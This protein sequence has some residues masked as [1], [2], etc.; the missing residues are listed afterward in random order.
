MDEFDEDQY[1]SL[2]R[3]RTVVDGVLVAV[4]G[5]IGAATVIFVM[6]QLG[7]GSLT[8]PL[9]DVLVVSGRH[10]L[11]AAVGVTAGIGLFYTRNRRLVTGT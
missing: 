6:I 9:G 2:G 4:C 3:P 11:A 8:T 7:Y 5:V 10:V 1:V